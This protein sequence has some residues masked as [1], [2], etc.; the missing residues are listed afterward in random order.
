MTALGSSI[1]LEAARLGKEMADR[2]AEMY[3]GRLRLAML[4][5]EGLNLIQIG[6]LVALLVGMA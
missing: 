6:I 3:K 2:R 1:E 5:L 4:V